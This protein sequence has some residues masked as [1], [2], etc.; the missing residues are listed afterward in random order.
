MEGCVG[1]KTGD[2]QNEAEDV[3]MFDA[4]TVMKRPAQPEEIATAY[5]SSPARNAPATSPENCCYHWWLYRRFCI[6]T[7]Q[8]P[9]R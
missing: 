2:R 4:D 1:Q 7:G 5:V 9:L 8:L 3:F 6:F